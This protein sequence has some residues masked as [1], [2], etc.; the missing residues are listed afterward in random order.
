MDAS[1]TGDAKSK[2]SVSSIMAR[3]NFLHY[4]EEV[5]LHE[6]ILDFEIKESSSASSSN[7][8]SSSSGSGKGSSSLKRPQSK[9]VIVFPLASLAKCVTEIKKLVS[10]A[11]KA[12]KDSLENSIKQYKK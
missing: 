9:R 12:E 10:L 11:E 2:S 8:S 4:E 1:S 6:A 7:G 5:L 3:S